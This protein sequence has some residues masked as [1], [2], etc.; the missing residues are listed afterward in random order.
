MM[1]R[2]IS[3]LAD[4]ELLVETDEGRTGVFDMTPYLDLEAFRPLRDPLQF[5]MV[6]NGGYFVEWQ[7][8]ADLSADTVEAHLTL[9]SA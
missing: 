1:I 3:V 7:C 2:S 6:R 9:R 5:R 8:G 4:H